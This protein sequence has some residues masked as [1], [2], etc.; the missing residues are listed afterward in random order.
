MPNL[1][2]FL[3]KQ[4]IFQPLVDKSRLN[5]CK[6]FFSKFLKILEFCR[7]TSNNRTFCNTFCSSTCAINLSTSKVVPLIL[8]SSIFCKKNSHVSGKYNLSS[9]QLTSREAVCCLAK[10]FKYSIYKALNTVY[11]QP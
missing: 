3:H 5:Y 11:T 7:L 2:V 9:S 6:V 10:V 8:H 1:S 4:S